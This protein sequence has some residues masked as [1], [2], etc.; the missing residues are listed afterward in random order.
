MQSETEELTP[1]QEQEQK[2]NSY[3]LDS[4]AVRE[5]LS[6]EGW[7]VVRDQ[8]YSRISQQQELLVEAKD[9]QEIF[10]A[11]GAYKALQGFN[12]QLADMYK[13]AEELENE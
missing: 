12:N 6:M 1:L 13:H 10:R 9:Q 5:V 3:N 11:Q 8:L 4:K 2:N 7:R